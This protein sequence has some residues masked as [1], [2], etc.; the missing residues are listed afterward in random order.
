MFRSPYS[1]LRYQRVAARLRSSGKL[2][3]IGVSRR[4][5]H[6]RPADGGW[7]P[8]E[9]GLGGLAIGLAS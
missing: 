6:G 1:L 5:S 9:A 8:F 7:G 2:N 3:F 4:F